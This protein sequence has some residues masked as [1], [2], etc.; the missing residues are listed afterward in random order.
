MYGNKHKINIYGKKYEYCGVHIGCD[1]Y[2][3]ELGELILRIKLDQES[4]LTYKKH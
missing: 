1:I 2:N 4:R 3:R